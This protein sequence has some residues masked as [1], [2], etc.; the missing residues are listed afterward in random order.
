MVFW[1]NLKYYFGYHR[2]H[3]TGKQQGDKKFYSDQWMRAAV[4]DNTMG[5]LFFGLYIMACINA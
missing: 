4:V 3:N 5:P 2:D 1:S